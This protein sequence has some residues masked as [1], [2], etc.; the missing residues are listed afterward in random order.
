M[1]N[2][3]NNWWKYSEVGESRFCWEEEDVDE[4]NT[5]LNYWTNTEDVLFILL[6]WHPFFNHF[7]V[8]IIFPLVYFDMD[9][10]SAVLRSR[11]NV[12]F[13]PTQTKPHICSLAYIASKL[14]WYRL[15]SNISLFIAFSFC[16][17][18]GLF[19]GFFLPC[20]Y[21]MKQ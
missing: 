6:N 13:F 5:G 2:Q 20:H 21:A 1:A 19:W 8:D 4:G 15:N 17:V 16:S 14:S 7:D 12:I 3:K 11:Q 9:I 10:N 18:E